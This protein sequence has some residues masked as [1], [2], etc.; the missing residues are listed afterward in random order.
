M[1]VDADVGAAVD[2]DADGT[3]IA[4]ASTTRPHRMLLMHP[5]LWVAFEGRTLTGLYVRWK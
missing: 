5:P 2:V 3:M 4:A 1:Y